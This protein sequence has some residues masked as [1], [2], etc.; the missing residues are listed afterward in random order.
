MQNTNLIPIKV[1]N[2]LDK[3]NLLWDIGAGYI[4]TFCKSKKIACTIAE[5]L[6]SYNVPAHL[7]LLDM[8]IVVI[9]I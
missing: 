9:Y 4:S 7:M 6:N 5:I 8:R 2:E 3:Y 1:P